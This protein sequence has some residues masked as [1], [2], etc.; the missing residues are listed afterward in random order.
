[1][2]QNPRT[3]SEDFAAI[4]RRAVEL[5][6]ALERDSE[7]QKLRGRVGSH[8]VEIVV[9]GGEVWEW[10]LSVTESESDSEVFSTWSEYWIDASAGLPSAK[11]VVGRL[12]A[13]VTLALELLEG[14]SELRVAKGEGLR[15][16]GRELFAGKVLELRVEE[17]WT[18]FEQLL[19]GA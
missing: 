5:G 19:H 1:M 2:A 18:P 14:A 6:Y 7:V 3:P 17:H 8:G 13:E 11:E 10:Y 12:V 9:P 16:L 4:G 15:F